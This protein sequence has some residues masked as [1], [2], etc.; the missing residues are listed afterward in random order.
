MKFY[1]K[2]QGDPNVQVIAQVPFE[3][4]PQLATAGISFAEDCYAPSEGGY[5]V[6]DSTGQDSAG[7]S[8]PNEPKPYERPW[9]IKA[10]PQGDPRVLWVDHPEMHGRV[11]MADPSLRREAQV[12]RIKGQEM[13]AFPTPAGE[14]LAE[15]IALLSVGIKEVPEDAP[16]FDLG[17]QAT[18]EAKRK[19]PFDPGQLVHEGL[20]EA[21]YEE[22][23]AHWQRFREAREPRKSV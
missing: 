10:D 14:V 22:V 23:S 7:Q 17:P 21:L 19:A 4:H 18:E 9:W 6:G 13:G 2:S 16:R 8:N 20:I 11:V 3:I 1:D 12:E 15:W 5:E